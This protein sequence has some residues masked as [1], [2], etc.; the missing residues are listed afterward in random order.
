D[1]DRIAKAMVVVVSPGVPPT[2]PAVQRAREARVEVIAEVDLAALALRSARWV[3]ITGTNGKTPT[4]ALTA[5]LLAACGH[6]AEAVGNIGRPV[7][8]VALEDP[9]P[10]WL[11]V[12]L[13]S[14]QLHDA[15]HLDLAV[16][17]M[18]NLSPDHLDRYP[19]L[20]AY[21]RD[22]ALL[23]R[24]AGPE[25]RWIT[26]GDDAE[27]QRL[28]D[29][30]PGVHQRWSLFDPADA[31]YNRR[32]REGLLMLGQQPVVSRS[33]FALL[34]DHNVSNALA[35]MLVAAHAGAT[36]AGLAE[37]L[38][39]FAPLPHRLEPVR[40]IR[41][42]VWIND[43][44][45][46]NLASTS[47]AV[48]ALDRP[49]VLLLGGRH[50]GEPYTR[51]APLLGHCR[52]V[53]AYGESRPIIEADLAGTVTVLGASSFDEVLDQASRLASPGDAVLLSPACSSF[54]MFAN[55]EERGSRFRAA[56][57]AL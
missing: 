1:L 21:Y 41:G 45:A 50:K 26:N 33:E 24:N 38:R 4:T 36:P 48:E 55:Y 19:S 37:G 52:G 3:G 20:E 35:A 54:D 14:F 13:S 11:V 51:L 27:V 40:E 34:G 12:E 39:R 53:V 8:D 42:V 32:E 9:P 25:C 47:V 7:S 56:V 43:S 18:T 23:F 6:R 15:P 49:F 2:A 29:G 30:V 57:E 44:K 17:V 46:T 10:D 31:W 16:G 22:K 28:A 5:A